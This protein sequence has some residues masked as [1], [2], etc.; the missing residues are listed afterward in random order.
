VSTIDAAVR[1]DLTD[2]Q[3]ALLKTPGAAREPARSA[4]AV[5]GAGPGRRG[6]PP[7]AHRLPLA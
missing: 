6:P 4:S 7:G 2:A 3:W 1:H 5:A